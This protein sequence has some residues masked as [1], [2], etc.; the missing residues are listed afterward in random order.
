MNDIYKK[1][2][3]D[4]N[5]GYEVVDEIKNLMKEKYQSDITKN[6]SMF[7]G[8]Y[9]LSQF[10]YK[11]PVLFAATDGVGTKILLASKYNI[12]SIGQDLVAMCVNDLICH[13]AKPVFFLDYISVNKID[14]K[15]ISKIIS[16]IIDVLKSF[17]CQ[18]IGG[19]TAEMSRVF[20]KDEL[21]IAGFSVGICEKE[22]IITNDKSEPNDIIVGIES[23]GLHSNGYSLI[24]YLIENNQININDILP[25]GKKVI[26]A[27]LEPTHVYV[28]LIL[29]LIKKYQIK[30]L[31]NNT[32]GGI[33]E[34]L[35]RALN[36]KTDAI[37]DPELYP[38]TE[39]FEYIQKQALLDKESMFK[40]LNM[41]IG[42]FLIVN[43]LEVDSILSTI[44][45]FNFSAYKIGVVTSGSK[46]INLKWSK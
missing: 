26:D 39:L 10:N 30:G 6:L 28:N 44:K 16:R 2:G 20:Q 34:N 13:G 40:S 37:I 21:D 19:E 27:L 17:D 3:V 42:F 31:A 23:S 29:E 24:H 33:I 43:P 11:A 8:M 38:K 22:K 18:L 15:V 4:I 5:S 14:K 7:A 46:M 1:A 9:D 12:N 41:G 45:S 32:G 35:A 36:S 25:S